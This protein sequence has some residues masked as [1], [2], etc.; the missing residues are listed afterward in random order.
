MTFALL[1]IVL[2]AG[3]CWYVTGGQV[4][5]TYDAY[6]E[7]DKVGISTDVSG[8]VQEV[9]VRDNQQVTEGQILTASTVCV[10]KTSNPTIVVMKSAK[11]GA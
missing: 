9:D 7:A 11:D 3:V 1:P 2:I 5:S 10:P 8:I 6:V 4:M